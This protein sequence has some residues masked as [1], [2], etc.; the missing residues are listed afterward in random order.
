MISAIISYI[1]LAVSGNFG[2]HSRNL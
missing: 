1:L 2:L